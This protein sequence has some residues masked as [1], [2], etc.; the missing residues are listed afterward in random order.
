MKFKKATFT[1]SGFVT[2][3][4]AA[5]KEMPKWLLQ[6][7]NK[8]LVQYTL[9]KAIPKNLD[10]EQNLV[11]LGKNGT[12]VMQFTEGHKQLQ[13]H[14]KKKSKG[15]VLLA[16]VSKNEFANVNGLFYERDNSPLYWDYFVLARISRLSKSKSSF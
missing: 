5:T 11:A 7:I 6:F 14:L 12:T 4:F 15:S 13:T 1:V 9:E 3:I 10:N 2:L 8:D 16:L